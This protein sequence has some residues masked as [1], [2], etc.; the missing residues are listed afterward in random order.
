MKITKVTPLGQAI[1]KVLV[2]AGITVYRVAQLTGVAQCTIS[3][4]RLGKSLAKLDTIE[5]IAKVA[6]VNA[7]DIL[8]IKEQIESAL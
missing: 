8:L 6:G 7:S 3:N 4:I 1:D 5:R 2:D